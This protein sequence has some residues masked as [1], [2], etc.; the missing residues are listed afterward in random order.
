MILTRYVSSK[1]VADSLGGPS[2]CYGM[3][4]SSRRYLSKALSR[5]LVCAFSWVGC[6][7][8]VHDIVLIDIGSCRHTKPFLPWW[9]HEFRSVSVCIRRVRAYI[10]DSDLVEPSL[11]ISVLSSISNSEGPS[12]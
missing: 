10:T 2:R 12:G 5:I 4:I 7:T 11:D 1:S 6:P 9:I 3:E 8:A